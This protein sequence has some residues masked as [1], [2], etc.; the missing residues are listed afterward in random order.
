[1]FS[2]TQVYVQWRGSH[3]P[4]AAQRLSEDGAH[5]A[6]P[7]SR[8]SQQPFAPQKQFEIVTQCF[9]ESSNAVGVT[10]QRDEKLTS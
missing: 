10:R 1:M 5:A 2:P 4:G 7:R 9:H 3:W 6:N 8:R